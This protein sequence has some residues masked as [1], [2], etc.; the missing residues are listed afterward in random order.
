MACSRRP[1]LEGAANGAM[2]F[3]ATT[4][5]WLLGTLGGLSGSCII[6]QRLPASSTLSSSAEEP[7][8][9]RAFQRNYLFVYLIIMLADWLQGTNMF[10]LYQ[11]YGVDISTLFVTGFASSAVFS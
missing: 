7:A 11:S 8:D 3:A 4:P 10:T 2:E 6:L 5:P 1:E 9:F